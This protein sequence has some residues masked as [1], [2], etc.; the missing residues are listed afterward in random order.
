[1]AIVEK[2]VTFNELF[3]GIKSFCYVKYELKTIYTDSKRS[4][5]LTRLKTKNF[6]KYYWTLKIIL[7]WRHAYRFETEGKGGRHGEKHQS[8]ASWK[9]PHWGP[10]LKTRHVPWPGIEHATF[11][12]MGRCS[13]QLSCTGQGSLNIL[14]EM[15]VL[16]HLCKQPQVPF[17][18]TNI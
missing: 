17:F 4:N 9:H 11:W 12:F 13:N 5:L 18:Y 3:Q 6:L 7:T 2:I 1:M 10:N 16:R 15:V 8:A 14:E